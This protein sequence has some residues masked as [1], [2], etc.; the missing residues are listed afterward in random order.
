MADADLEAIRQKRMA[1]LQGQGPDK[2]E[3]RAAMEDRKNQMLTQIL[4]QAARARL[5]SIAVVK[6]EKA[7]MVEAML[8][9]MYQS[10][11]LPGKVSEAQL[12]QML[13]QVADQGAKKTTITVWS[14][15]AMRA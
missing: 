6:P 15:S 12:K 10:G 11:Q 14:A 8:L 5:S 13:E 9:R 2:A 3:Q 1:E 7:Q 4:D